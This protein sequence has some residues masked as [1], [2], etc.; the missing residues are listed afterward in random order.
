MLS[1]NYKLQIIAFFRFMAILD[2]NMIGCL[3]SNRKKGKVF[4]KTKNF[5]ISINR[6]NNSNNNKNKSTD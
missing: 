4:E 1:E 3:I 2:F 6:N 5:E